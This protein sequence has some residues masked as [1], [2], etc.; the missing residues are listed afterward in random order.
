MKC[1]RI[2]PDTWVRTRWP[3]SNSTR[4]MAFGKGSVTVPSTSMA[5]F[6]A[7]LQGYLPPAATLRAPDEA[8]RPPDP[9]ADPSV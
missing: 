7:T 6:F 3:L 2:F 5:S 8:K 9:E 4:N 1:I